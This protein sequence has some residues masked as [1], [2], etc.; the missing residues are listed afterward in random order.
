MC[1]YRSTLSL[2]C[3]NLLNSAF[4]GGF[5]FTHFVCLEITY[6][7]AWENPDLC[8]SQY[9]N[10]QSVGNFSFLLHFNSIVLCVFPIGYSPIT[11]NEKASDKGYFRLL[12]NHCQFLNLS[13]TFQSYVW[14][15][16]SNVLCVFPIGYYPITINEMAP[17]KRYFRLLTN[18]Y[19]LPILS[20]IFNLY[21]TLIAL[22]FVYSL[23][24]T[25]PSQLIQGIPQTEKTNHNA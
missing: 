10:S 13:V 15:F 25:T 16:Y 1:G 17:D 14:R 19:Q 18:H 24:D 8:K 12:T 3:H 9:S 5:V 11:I 20:V 2:M 23:F 22:F 21:G 4:N 7:I 6:H